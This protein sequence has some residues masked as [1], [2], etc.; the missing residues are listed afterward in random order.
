MLTLYS[1]LLMLVMSL[2][3]GL[4]IA[5]FSRVFEIKQDPRVAQVASVLP[6]YNCGACGFAGCNDYALAVVEGKA[7]DN[8]CSPGGA[9]VAAKIRDLLSAS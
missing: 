2:V 3:L 5:I 8:R 7:P 6:A 1:V 4:L 9:P